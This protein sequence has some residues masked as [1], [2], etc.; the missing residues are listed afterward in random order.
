MI[1]S[2]HTTSRW[3]KLPSNFGFFVINYLA[4]MKVQKLFSPVRLHS[5]KNHTYNSTIKKVKVQGFFAMCTKL[6]PILQ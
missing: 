5:L 6:W 1:L 4:K 2:Q 3:T